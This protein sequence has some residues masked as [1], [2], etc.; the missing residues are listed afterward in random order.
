MAILSSLIK[1]MQVQANLWGEAVRYAVYLLNRLPTKVIGYCTPYQAWFVKRP[2]VEH[3]R[4][5][6]CIAYV[7]VAGPHLKK[8]DDRSQ[9]MVYLGVEDG[10]RTDSSIHH[11]AKSL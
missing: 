3:L 10:K 6:G 9:E 11:E 4:V 2:H 8:L 1:S 5:F 7:K